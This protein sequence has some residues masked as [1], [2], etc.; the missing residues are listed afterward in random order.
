MRME[1]TRSEGG[2]IVALSS[3]FCGP[4]LECRVCG[5]METIEVM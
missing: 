2:N 3:S 1:T 5:G 4:G